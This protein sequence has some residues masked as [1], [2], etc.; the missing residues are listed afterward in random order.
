M[1]W[2]LYLLLAITAATISYQ[3]IRTRSVAWLLFPAMALIG[4]SNSIIESDSWQQAL[5]NFSINT[6]FILL[7]FLL[8]ILYFILRGNKITSLVNKKIGLGD[9]LFL[10]SACFFFSPLNFLL[11]YCGSLFFSLLIH[12]LMA[13]TDNRKNS[14][15]IPLAGWQSVFLLLF[16]SIYI[17]A[18]NNFLSDEW[19][20]KIIVPA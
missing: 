9:I 8:L 18:G 14:T 3:D 15:T 17:M 10:A 1:H 4:I 6:S 19:L 5:Y 7:Q 16:V 20:I 11:F 12:S 13:G 2:S